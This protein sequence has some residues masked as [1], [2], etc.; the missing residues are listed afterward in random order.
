MTNP[1]TDGGGEE[2]LLSLL[3]QESTYE[4]GRFPTALAVIQKGYVC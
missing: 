1:E 3:W 2:L 4:H